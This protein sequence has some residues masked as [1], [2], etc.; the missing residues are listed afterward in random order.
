MK[1]QTIKKWLKRL[2]LADERGNLLL[3]SYLMIVL[4]IGMGAAFMKLATNEVR[5]S[6][7]QR[8][9]TVALHI[10]EAGIERGLYD[11]RQDFVNAVGTPSWT[12]G[13]INGYSVATNS[14][15]YTSIPYSSTTLNTGTYTV[16]LK[17]DA[18]IADDVWLR[19]VGTVNDVT[20]TLDVYV[21]MVNLSPWGNAI[22][23]G[24]GASGTMVNGNV[25]IRGSV[26]ILGTGLNPGDYAVDMGG[27]AEIVG[28][29]YNGVPSSL[30]AK[31]PALP[32]VLHNGELVDSLGAELRVKHGL[33]GFSGSSS[34]GE[35]NVAGN[36]VKETVDGVFVTDGFGGSH[37][38]SSVHSDNGTTNAYDL[39]DS[40]QFPSLSDPYPGYAT[41]QD[42]LKANAYVVT[43]N[44]LSNLTPA[45]SLSMGDAKGSITMDGAGN[46]TIS[47][48]V[49]VDNGNNFAINKQGSN[50][51]VNYTGKGS[52]LVTGN[53]NINVDLLTAGN[54]SFPNNIM[55]IMT[56]NNITFNEANIDV[57]GLFYGE[58]TITV[59]K[60]TDMMGTIV[61]NFFDVG[62]NVPSVFQVPATLNNMPPG[63]IGSNSTWYMVVAWIKS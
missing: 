4:L 33:V 32:K 22:F 52:L 14:G 39:G 23:A 1:N 63:M 41:Y 9:S 12:D 30:L 2:K 55:G 37:G 45:S 53:V 62:T 31:V 35:A 20:M 25:N 8:L 40:V 10:A 59:S 46:M 61:T 58:N 60:Q 44:A 54:N 13:D 36:A 26:H 16:S 38:A 29:N 34:A 19:S 11:L 43:S 48:I 15:T 3:I 6:E 17:R 51:T 49:Y 5:V 50:K 18:T 57:M 28:N 21:R 56:P 7:R 24:S 42:Y 27:T 47:G